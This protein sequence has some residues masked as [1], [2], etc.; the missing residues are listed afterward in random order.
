MYD[1]ENPNGF[2]SN[3]EGNNDDN[4]SGTENN[5]FEEVNSQQVSQD[6]VNSSEQNTEQTAEQESS[7]Y[8]QSYVNDEHHN[9]DDV[10]GN[11]T[12]YSQGSN[13]S[14]NDSTHYASALKCR[15]ARAFRWSGNA[16]EIR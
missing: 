14:S 8:R 16:L 6:A 7:V 15:M 4:I 3:P 5:N 11:G 12:Y 2:G 13:N 1:N 9:A 10:S